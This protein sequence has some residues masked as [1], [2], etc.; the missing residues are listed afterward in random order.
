MAGGQSRL[1][2]PGSDP[3]ANTPATSEVGL[4]QR[5]GGEH[6]LLYLYL[7]MDGDDQRDG[8]RRLEEMGKDEQQPG[9]HDDMSN[10][11]G[12]EAEG[13]DMISTLIE[14]PIPQPY[15]LWPL[16][17]QEFFACPWFLM[18]DKTADVAPP[19]FIQR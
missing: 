18:S 3:A 8:Q 2:Q 12:V 16:E 4:A 1:K 13:E 11:S 5:C 15:N 7:K 6:A 9:K 17:V 19:V 10:K 14:K